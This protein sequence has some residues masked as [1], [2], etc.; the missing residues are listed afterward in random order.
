[1][2][3]VV[4]GSPYL[5][6]RDGVFA[7]LDEIHKKTPVTLVIHGGDRGAEALGAEWAREHGIKQMVRQVSWHEGRE[8]GPK[9]NLAIL[10][11]EKPDMVVAIKPAKGTRHLIDNALDEGIAVVEVALC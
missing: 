9:N 10:R 3:I 1:M 11:V 6:D 5:E 4:A 7:A 2:K 8:A